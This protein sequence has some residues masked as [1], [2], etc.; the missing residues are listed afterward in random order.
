MKT[1]IIV[2]VILTGISLLVVYALYQNMVVIP[3]QELA[4]KMYQDMQKQVNFNECIEK[5]DSDYSYNWDAQCQANGKDKD[6]TLTR[7]IAD[8]VAESWKENKKNCVTMY[9]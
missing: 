1:K 4:Y 5:A 2:G 8:D 3:R 9:K 6:C 7:T